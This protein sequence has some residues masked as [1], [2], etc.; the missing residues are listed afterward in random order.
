MRR[1]M[2]LCIVF[3]IPAWIS[4]QNV[5]KNPDQ[6]DDARAGRVLQLTKELTVSDEQGGYYFKSPKN[7]QIAPDGSIFLLDEDQFL[8]FDADGK[9]QANLFRKGQG[10]GE[11]EQIMDYIFT[12]D[13]IA[14]LQAQPNKIVL[15][16]MQGE[17]LR[18]IK[19][20]DVCYRLFTFYDG[21]YYGAH[22]SRPQFDKLGDE[23]MI[24]DITWNIRIASDTG[25]VEVTE[26]NFPVSWY[27]QRIKSAVIANYIVDF[28]ALPAQERYM[29]ISHTQKY[30]LKLL[31]LESGQVI[32][33]FSREYAR[34]RMKPDKTG[35][36]EVRPD[37]FTLV[38]PVDHYNDIQKFFIIEDRIWVLTSTLDQEKGFLVDV[39]D[40]AGRYLDNFYLPFQ[41]SI[42]QAGLARHPLTIHGGCVYV[43]EYDEDGIPTLVKYRITN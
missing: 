24:L 41:D 11:V 8:K 42:K 10:P 28:M 16:D 12:G 1:I 23:P 25:V 18:E 36:V 26:L 15:M 4:A 39:F 35:K 17:F 5:I 19:P 33:E 7:I 13:G 20:D 30:L 32:R 37:T 14:V 2:S 38:P 34:I 31:D 27:A 43:M 29:V 3:L 40:M 22:N 6:P 21:R 9:F